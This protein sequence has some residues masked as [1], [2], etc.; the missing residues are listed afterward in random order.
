M[1][2]PRRR[3]AVANREALLEAAARVLRTAPDASIDA[4]AAEAGLS[5]RAIYGHFPSRDALVSE[6]LARG[7]ERV[8]AAVADL[9]D[10]DPAR[11]VARL[12]FALWR[13]IAH[14]RLV[15][16][17]LVTGP[18]EADVAAG[19]APVRRTLREALARG[20]D[21]G[22]FRR[23]VGVDVTARL[24]E[25]TAIAVLD[26]AV[27]GALGDDEAARLVAVSALGLAGLGAEQ[28]AA[29]AEGARAADRGVVA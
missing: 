26:V 15:A 10:P 29:V 23:D 19:M 1:T 22:V 24:I 12:G 11:L 6:L 16:R 7:T 28:A 3:D 20:R 25:E 21:A 2:S 8:S 17:S 27:D 18:W 13:E 9:A 14:V 4:I 5:R